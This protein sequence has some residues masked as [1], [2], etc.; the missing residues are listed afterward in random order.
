MRRGS[1]LSALAFKYQVG[2]YLINMHSSSNLLM[3][4]MGT[5]TSKLL[6]RD[7]I[8]LLLLANPTHPVTS[9]G[10]LK[11]PTWNFLVQGSM[12]CISRLAVQTGRMSKYE[13]SQLSARQSREGQWAGML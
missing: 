5:S 6:S 3:S 1:L 11:V 4:A 7:R 8:S 13:L 10:T 12:R 9:Q 2:L